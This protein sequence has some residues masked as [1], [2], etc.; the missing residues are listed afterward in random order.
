VI[1]DVSIG[2]VELCASAVEVIVAVVVEVIVGEPP[3]LAE[4]VA[5]PTS[6]TPAPPVTS[7]PPPAP[8]ATAS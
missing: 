8:P 4:S 1:L 6:V 2:S 3:P 5:E 7:A